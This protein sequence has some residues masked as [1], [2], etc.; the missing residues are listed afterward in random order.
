MVHYESKDRT[1]HERLVTRVVFKYIALFGTVMIMM[2]LSPMF[3]ESS[4][5]KRCEEADFVLDFRNQL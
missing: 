1:H 2:A 4:N 5:A 3:M